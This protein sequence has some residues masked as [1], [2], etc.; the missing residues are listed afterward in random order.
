MHF[1]GNILSIKLCP[2]VSLSAIVNISVPPVL[3]L[4]VNPV[5]TFTGETELYKISKAEIN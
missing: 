5:T 4:S 2:F 1:M 3:T